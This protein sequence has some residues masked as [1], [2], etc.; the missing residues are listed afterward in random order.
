[1]SMTLII[2]FLATG[3]FSGTIAGLLGVGGGM[4]IVPVVVWILSSQGMA[5]DYAIKIALASSLAIII[6]TSISSALAHHR[7][8]ALRWDIVKRMLAGIIIG[9]AIGGLLVDWLPRVLLARCVCCRLLVNCSQ[10]VTRSQP[11][12]L[13][14]TTRHRWPK[15]RG[16]RHWQHIRIAGHRRRLSNGSFLTLV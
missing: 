9:T 5:E 13:P 14:H 12:T 2:A 7:S 3:V 10:D 11:Q 16:Q 8:G 1:M 6:P 15:Y 4:I